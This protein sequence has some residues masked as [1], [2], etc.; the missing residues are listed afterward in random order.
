MKRKSTKTQKNTPHMMMMMMGGSGTLLA[1]MSVLGLRR[2]G[3]N[4]GHIFG[5]GLR[6]FHGVQ[7]EVAKGGCN[8]EA[9]NRHCWRT[10]RQFTPLVQ[11]FPW[12]VSRRPLGSLYS[13][14]FNLFV[15]HHVGVRHLPPLLLPTHSHLS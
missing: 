8:E 2:A 10:V 9:S 3:G 15:L 14:C 1:R 7:C 13:L 6:L 4:F 11:H 12:V 5:S